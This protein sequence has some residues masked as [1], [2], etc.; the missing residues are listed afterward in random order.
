M[1]GG[2]VTAE[3][4]ASGL[5]HCHLTTAAQLPWP[6]AL[7]RAAALGGLGPGSPPAA[8]RA[9][10]GHSPRSNSQVTPGS[11][12]QPVRATRGEGRCKDR[13][14]RQGLREDTAPSDLH[15]EQACETALNPRQQME[16]EWSGGQDMRLAPKPKSPLCPD[17]PGRVLRAHGLP[18]MDREG[19]TAWCP[20]PK[21]SVTGL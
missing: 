11:P 12:P 20:G 6:E 18:S 16:A 9:K 10:Q 1:P 19:W 7:P 21:P 13:T 8:Q 5:A 4:Q 3:L 14:G 15:R 2:T 17:G